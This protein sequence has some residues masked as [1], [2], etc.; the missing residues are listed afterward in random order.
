MVVEAQEE[1]RKFRMSSP[2]CRP[3][4]VLLR[5]YYWRRRVTWGNG[6][7]SPL[8]ETIAERQLL[9]FATNEL[10][11]GANLRETIATIAPGEDSDNDMEMD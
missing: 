1:R 11:Q 3:L 4:T 5:R 7:R 10:P 9:S 2:Q 8:V 6:T